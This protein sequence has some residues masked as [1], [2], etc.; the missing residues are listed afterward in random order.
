MVDFIHYNDFDK[1][2]E[3]LVEQLPELLEPIERYWKHEGKPGSDPGPYILVVY[4]VQPYVNIL[5][6]MSP[7]P[8]RDRLL[9]HFFQTLEQMLSSRDSGIRDLAYIGFLED[10]S[11]LWYQRA[12]NFLGPKAVNELD[13]WEPQWRTA[14]RSE[15]ETTEFED[16]G[17]IYDAR[18]SIV[19]MTGWDG[20]SFEVP[21]ARIYKEPVKE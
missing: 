14:V 20:E 8:Q 21:G 5:L 13:Q 2:E 4:V 15:V 3:W 7:S 11:S 17:D 19:K 12:A 1:V 10:C 9:I 6:A 16:I 18:S